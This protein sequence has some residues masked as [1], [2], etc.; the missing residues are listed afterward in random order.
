ML[1]LTTSLSLRSPLFTYKYFYHTAD[2][3]SLN[4]NPLRSLPLPRSD[5]AHTRRHVPRLTIP[6]TPLVQ[7]IA[8]YTFGRNQQFRAMV[9]K[10]QYINAIAASQFKPYF[11]YIHCYRK[12][13]GPPKPIIC[14]VHK[15]YYGANINQVKIGQCDVS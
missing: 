10:S 7:L 2:P 11:H 6:F 9:L 12:H 5:S 8:Q 4:V 14:W 1:D 3:R 13:E 15:K